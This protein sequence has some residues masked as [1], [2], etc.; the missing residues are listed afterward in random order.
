MY[1]RDQLFIDGKWTAPDTGSV[2]SVISPHSEAV[3]GRAACAGPADVNR[4]VDAARA[5][6]D[7]GPWPRMQPAERIEAITRL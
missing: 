5:A 1:D 7:T 3:I 4:A 2:I 6:F